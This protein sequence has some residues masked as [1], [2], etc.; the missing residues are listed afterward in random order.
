MVIATCFSPRAEPACHAL[1][2][3]SCAHHGHTLS[4]LRHEGPWLTHR[5]KDAHLLAYARTLPDTELVL[6]SDATDAVVTVQPG[7]IEEKYRA[8]RTPVVCSAEANCWPDAALAA[9]FPPSAT[10][11]RYLNAGGLIGEAGALVALLEDYPGWLPAVGDESAPPDE[12]FRWSNQF[13]WIRMYLDHPDRIALDREASLFIALTAPVPPV[14]DPYADFHARGP[15]SP[16]VAA[17]VAWLQEKTT[18]RDGRLT[19][20]VTGERPCHVHFNNPILR[21]LAY[22]GFFAGITPWL[23]PGSPAG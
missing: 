9:A 7:E 6:F 15:Q 23:R 1:L 14:R 18:T 20:T 8:F 10:D 3:A 13:C 16:Q 2:A 11:L 17:E 19:Y 22:R 21:L 4:A 5:L 12:P